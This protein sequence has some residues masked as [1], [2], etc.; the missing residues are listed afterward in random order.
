MP[1]IVDIKTPPGQ[2]TSQHLAVPGL[3]DALDDATDKNG[4]LHVF[5]VHG[6]SNHPFG[7]E[8]EFQRRFGVSD[9]PS[10]LRHLD[11]PAWRASKTSAVIG[12]IQEKQF[13]PLV[14]RLARELGV[15][16]SQTE[17]PT[18][19]WIENKNR[20]LGY[21]LRWPFE[22]PRDGTGR[23]PRMV[24]HLNA[25]A[26]ASIPHKIK[27]LGDDNHA[28]RKDFFFN[29]ALKD[30]LVSWGLMDAALYVGAERAN[31][32]HA[33]ET[34]INWLAHGYPQKETPQPAA[35]DRYA[36]G[37]A[38][39]GSAI[40]LDT[41]KMLLAEPDSP[42]VA[43][44]FRSGVPLYLFANQI[45][46]LDPAS[47][48]SGAGNRAKITNSTQALKEIARQLPKDAVLTVVAYND[49]S[50]MLGFPVPAIPDNGDGAKIRVI[51]VA[52]RNQAFG[53]WWLF[54]NPLAAHTGHPRTRTV[55]KNMADGIT[56]KAAATTP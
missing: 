53:I 49:P 35:G 47:V 14:D 12:S 17:G 56:V 11:D 54:S 55:M 44:M 19:E 27:L 3:N 38:S 4:R 9:Y 21:Q 51:N 43:R 32:Q 37:A 30:G 22:G 8:K 13:D 40:T 33:V 1:G 39:L 42:T 46:L 2:D 48:S 23:T 16:P 6:M 24:I 18:L 26:L 52:V 7:P 5:L 31:M 15:S 36:F 20:L 29:R 10:L 45:P 25:W 28:G 50:D 34:G 41:L